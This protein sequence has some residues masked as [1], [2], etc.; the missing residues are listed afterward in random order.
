MRKRL[1]QS[2]YGSK[3][4]KLNISGVLSAKQKKRGTELPK[5]NVGRMKPES[6]EKQ[7]REE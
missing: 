6:R 4:K 3:P 2:D 5:S 7:K 1:K